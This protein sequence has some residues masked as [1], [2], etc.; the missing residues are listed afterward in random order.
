[1]SHVSLVAVQL[2]RALDE[3]RDTPPPAALRAVLL[4]GGPIPADLVT[5]AL[6]A[7][8]P[9]VPTYGLSEVAS[10]ATAL[11]SGDAWDR[12]GSAGVPLPGVRLTLADEDE[13]GSARSSRGAVA[14][15]R[16]PG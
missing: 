11:A 4:G 12:P 1:M 3:A 7:G 15:L 8:W 13:T 9:V 6:R 14:L 16:V 10:G 5:R 2:A